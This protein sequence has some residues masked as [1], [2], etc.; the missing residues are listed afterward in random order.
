MAVLIDKN[1]P[2][3]DLEQAKENFE[4]NRENLDDVNGFKDIIAHSRFFNI[5]NHGYVGSVF[6][7]EGRDGKKYIGGYALRK[8]HL[9]VVDAIRQV[10]GMYNELYAQTRHLNAVIALKKAGF[11]WFS[12]QH[13]LLRKINYKE[14]NN[15]KSS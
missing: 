4:K 8:H 6:V 9:D 3:F 1:S 2:F 15:G 14:K 5:H 7:Y 13:K 11:K 12:R 10:A